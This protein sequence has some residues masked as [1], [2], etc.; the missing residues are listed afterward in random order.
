[1]RGLL[2]GLALALIAPA[3]WAQTP[4]QHDWCR[5]PTATADQTIDGCTALIQSGRET[6]A[7]KALDYDIRGSAYFIKGLYD[8]AIADYTRSIALKPE[9]AMAANAYNSRGLAYDTKR[10]YDQ[11]IGDFTQAIA[12]KPDLAFAYAG[13]GFA[14]EEKGLRDPAVADYRAALKLDSSLDLA[15]AGLK[16]LG[17]TP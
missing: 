8:Q 10:L 5:S 2:I 15:Q 14:Y 17:V 3:A 7:V 4:Q 11:A 6:M 13:R 16:R 12:L 1:M 9:A